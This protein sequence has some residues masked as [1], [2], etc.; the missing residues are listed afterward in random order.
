[1][2]QLEALLNGIHHLEP[3]DLSPWNGP[4]EVLVRPLSG[5]EASQ[6]EWMTLKGM[7]AVADMQG[8]SFNAR[9][10]ID[11]LGALLEN[12]RLA[13]VKTVEFGLSHSG[14]TCTPEQAGQLPSPWIDALAE[15]IYR[16]SGMRNPDEDLDSFRGPAGA[17]GIGEDGRGVDAAAVP[18][19]DSAG[20]DPEGPDAVA[21]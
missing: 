6:M 10:T 17:A 18:G 1:M 3:V 4:S 2:S 5:P 8:P 12:Q 20:A 11:D 14:E 13:R 7:G 16:V 21:A 15:V 9:P 19:G